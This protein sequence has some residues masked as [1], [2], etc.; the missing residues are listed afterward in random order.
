MKLASALGTE[1]AK[2]HSAP[3]RLTPDALAAYCNVMVT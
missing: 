1:S 2:A 3:T